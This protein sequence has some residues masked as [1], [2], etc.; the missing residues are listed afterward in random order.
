MKKLFG[1]FGTAGA[2]IA[3]VV[4]AV[5]TLGVSPAQAAL[6]EDWDS[7]SA[8]GD[9]TCGIRH[10]GKLY[11]WGDDSNGQVGDGNFISTHKTPGRIGTF[12]DWA[13]VSAGGAHTCGVRSNGKLYCWGADYVSQVGNGV[14]AGSD[15]LSPQRIGD[16]EDWADVSAGRLHTCGVRENGKLYCWGYGAMGQLGYVSGGGDPNVPSRVGS[17]E[18]WTTVSAGGDHT[19]GVRANGKLY[20]WGFDNAGQVG[21]GNGTTTTGPPTPRRIGSF[22]DWSDVSAG[23]AHTCGI[24]HDGKLYC[25]GG[26][27]SGEVGNGSPSSPVDAP[28]RIGTFEDWSEVSAGG[29]HTCGVRR[30]GKLYCWGYD[31]KGQVGDGDAAF[32]A[33]TPRRIGSFEDWATASAGSLHSCGVREN[34]K[35][36]CWGN[37]DSGQVGDGDFIST[38]TTPGRI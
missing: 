15:V 6:F 21:D 9:H 19:C 7:V 29:G 24:R 11:C 8:G 18:D 17:F 38:H 36:Y 14:D 32:A 12:E 31:N 3:S 25:W 34:G 33:I 23:G 22:E 1:A 13:E 30:N 27:G 37:D 4:V 35:L 26:D 10:D 28:Q 5:A 16:F 20:C 2:M